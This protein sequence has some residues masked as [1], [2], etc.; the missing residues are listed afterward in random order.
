MEATRRA[1]WRTAGSSSPIV[2]SLRK[3]AMNGTVA[4]SSSMRATA[5]TCTRLI[6]RSWAMRENSFP[7]CPARVGA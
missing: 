2:R 4:P 7:G 6:C 1:I 5:S 3:R